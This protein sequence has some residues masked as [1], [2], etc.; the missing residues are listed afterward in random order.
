MSPP[1]RGE[2]SY[3]PVLEGVLS[4]PYAIFY[5]N[6][7][8]LLPRT[9]VLPSAGSSSYQ[10]VFSSDTFEKCYAELYEMVG[11]ISLTKP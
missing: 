8:F 6:A 11:L 4:T 2:F 1:P 9:V 10:E 3:Y 7:I 5:T